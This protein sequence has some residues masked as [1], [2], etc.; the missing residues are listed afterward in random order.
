REENQQ[1]LARAALLA[2]NLLPKD[3]LGVETTD[4]NSGVESMFCALSPPP[5]LAKGL[6]Q[7][8]KAFFAMS[9][10][11]KLD[12]AKLDAL[13]QDLS[14]AAEIHPEGLLHYLRGGMLVLRAGDKDPRWEQAEQAFLAAARTPSIARIQRTALLE[15]V[16][17]E[18]FLAHPNWP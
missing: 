6:S 2:K 12:A 9:A 8:P 11:E 14:A 17:I 7:I 4:L 13:I 5:V 1:R 3:L 10:I 16:R 18:A 15:A